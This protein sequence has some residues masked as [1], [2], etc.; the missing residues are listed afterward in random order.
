MSDL[1]PLTQ[2]EV[3]NMAV[4]WYKKLDVHAPM[5][6]ILPMLNDGDLEMVFPEAT[7]HGLAAFEG[8]YQGVIRIFFDEEHEVTEC[9][10]AVNGT[11]AEVK[12][13]V[14]WA[15]SRWNP[16][17]RYSDRIVL[18]AYQTWT[19]KRH[20]KTGLPVVTKYTVDRLEYQEGS[21][22]L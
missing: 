14:R 2:E 5:V 18:D 9:A 19:V 15:A 1:A 6:E 12:I 20:E 22:K 11:V 17:A 7:L 13:V 8:W 16:P 21:A 3:K 4:E 10:V